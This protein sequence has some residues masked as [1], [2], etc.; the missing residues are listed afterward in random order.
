MLVLGL[1]TAFKSLVCFPAVDAV[2]GTRGTD[3]GLVYASMAEALALITQVTAVREFHFPSRVFLTVGAIHR[4]EG[5]IQGKRK[6]KTEMSSWWAD[7]KECAHCKAGLGVFKKTVDID[8]IECVPNS[9][10]VLLCSWG[11]CCLY[12][13]NLP[14]VRDLPKRAHAYSPQ[15]GEGSFALFALTQAQITGTK[16]NAKKHLG[17]KDS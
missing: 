15:P 9:D 6:E 5:E 4:S 11:C 3:G 10:D 14:Y 13:M 1:V 12:M 7:G 17:I 8:H 2:C 16:D